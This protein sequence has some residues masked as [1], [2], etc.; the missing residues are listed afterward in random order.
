M[1]DKTTPFDFDTWWALY[2]GLKGSPWEADDI[3]DCD[4]WLSTGSPS[5]VPA[6]EAMRYVYEAARKWE[7][8]VD[9][10][11]AVAAVLNATYE[12][13]A[14]NGWRPVDVKEM[15]DHF[16][17]FYREFED[18]LQDRLDEEYS[19]MPLEWLGDHGRRELEKEICKDSEI[20]IEEGPPGV[21]V[22]N[23]PG[24]TP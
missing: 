15:A 20:W 24:R 12:F 10:E 14:C 5:G 17:V 4:V 1:T 19:R 18:P 23:K 6:A 11:D 21:W 3:A 16:A 9:P 22:F 8:P 2:D 7:G 13:T